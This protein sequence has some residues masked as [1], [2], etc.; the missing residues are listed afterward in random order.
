MTEDEARQI[1][2]TTAARERGTL[3]EVLGLQ[4]SATTAE[5]EDAY[6]D[7]AR[8]WHPDRF[9]SRE[10]GERGP[11]LEENFGA[12]TRAYR[13]LRDEVKRK[14]YNR[15]AGITVK[16]VVRTP[17][18]VPPPPPPAPAPRARLSSIGNGVNAGDTSPGGTRVYET[19]IGRAPPPTPTPTPTPKPPRAVDKIRQ[20]LGEQLTRARAYHD[21][22]KADF[23]AGRFAKAESALYL[24]MKF[25]P[26]NPSYTQLY[27]QAATQARA[28]R[29]K[30]FLTQ[31]EQEESYGRLK[32][33]MGLYLKAAECDPP[34]GVAFFRL[35]HLQRSQDQDTRGAVA[36]L[37]K[38]VSKE[39]RNV[40]YRL[41]LG[42]LYET[43]KLHA[44]AVREA[45]VALEVD[46][47]SEA[48]KA[49]IKRLKK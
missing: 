12:A 26:H 28:G 31:A 32:E 5:V 25:D 38:A 39:P 3:Y 2:A 36:N 16:S 21:A 41:A 17:A 27:E 18:V 34:D 24:A 8:Q 48:A 15:E 47:K 42:E 43:L 13:I 1:D 46:P 19:A 40:A 49:L 45:Q 35:A 44:N 20:H 29:G 33:A 22:G 30:G 6:H 9:Y 10:T 37:R 4:P 7:L 23:D 11:L 14:S